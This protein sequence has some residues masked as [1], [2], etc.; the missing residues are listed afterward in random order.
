MVVRIRYIILFTLFIFLSFENMSG[1]EY[2]KV[3]K[4]VND[5]IYVDTL[6]PIEVYPKRGMFRFYKRWR[7]SRKIRNLKK[8][9]PYA[10][11]AGVL[12][13]EI[14]AEYVK[15]KTEREKKRYI[16]KAEKRL[17]AQFEGELR[18]M[19]ISQGRMLIKLIFRET[20]NTTYEILKEFKGGFSAF[21]WHSVARLFGSSLKYKYDKN[22]DDADLERL[23]LLYEQGKL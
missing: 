10:K 6:D 15:L 18:N 12:L 14:N 23:V 5:T 13:K 3:K 1:Q 17:F 11:R 22:G 2:V 4:I 9:Y 20:G 19:T 8:V 21:F 7:Y 16:K